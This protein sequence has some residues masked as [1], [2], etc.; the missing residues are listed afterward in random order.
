MLDEV[1][2]F[3]A[4]KALSW[5][6]D[7][8]QLLKESKVQFKSDENIRKCRRPIVILHAEGNLLLSCTVAPAVKRYPWKQEIMGPCPGSS[9]LANV[10]AAFD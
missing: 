9:V 10:C 6:V 8:K 3:F 1:K 2:T 7:I 4:A 5:V